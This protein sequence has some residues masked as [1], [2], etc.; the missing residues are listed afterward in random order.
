MVGILI[1]AGDIQALN[2]DAIPNLANLS[3]EFQG[4]S[5]DP[6]GAFSVPYQWG[7]TGIGVDTAVVGTD[8]PR[9]WALIFDPEV[10]EEYSGSIS[11]LSI[12]MVLVISI[13]PAFMRRPNAAV[14]IGVMA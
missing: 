11:L 10:A 12:R 14:T 7:Y 1:Q 13:M 9:S 5:Y 8:F 4:L 6:N 2:K 3:A